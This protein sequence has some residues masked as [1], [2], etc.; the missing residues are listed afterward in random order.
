MP[1][2]S[3]GITVAKRMDNAVEH[4]YA[5]AA[6]QS[7]REAKFTEVV[8]AFCEPDAGHVVP[9]FIDAANVM[10]HVHTQHMGCFPNFRYGLN[11][12][13]DNTDSDWVMLLQDD[14]IWHPDGYTAMQRGFEELPAAGFLSPY[15]SRAMV[16]G[17]HAGHSDLSVDLP[18][19]WVAH[20]F[21]NKAFWGA[22]A[23]AFPRQSAKD[24]VN[25]P[26]F[27][28]HDHHR[29]VDVVVGN[30]TRDMGKTGYVHV[31][32]ICEHI[33]KHS[34]IGRDRFP[35]N[36]WGRHGLRFDPEKPL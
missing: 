34:T 2:L 3:I 31:P 27:I 12:L 20:R 8:H 25:F 26:R 35:G 16:E 23:M 24:L 5:K 22:L 14:C 9:S 21:H 17:G 29:K 19:G 18:A 33:G 11:W 6:I 15:T 30:C 4:N 1:T 10:P 32:S 28:Q 13:V 7:L 36:K